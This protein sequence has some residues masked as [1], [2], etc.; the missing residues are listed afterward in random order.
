M[1]IVGGFMV[2]SALVVTLTICI[3]KGCW[4][5][6]CSKK[7]TTEEDA[8]AL[9]YTMDRNSLMREAEGSA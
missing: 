6:N 7:K 9:V 2:I 5:P 3:V 8:E 1:T 4:K